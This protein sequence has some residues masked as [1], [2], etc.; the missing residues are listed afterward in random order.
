MPRVGNSTK[1]R[2]TQKR[3]QEQE[4]TAVTPGERYSCTESKGEATGLHRCNDDNR[5]S[6]VRE[7]FTYAVAGCSY[8]EQ[9][10]QWQ[11]QQ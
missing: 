4:G 2:G 11:H 7:R 5:Y 8:N 1:K 9:A 3:H 6:P 10:Q